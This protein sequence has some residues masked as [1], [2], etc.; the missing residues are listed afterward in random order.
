[1][2]PYLYVNG[3]IHNKIKFLSKALNS[4]FLQYVSQQSSLLIEFF[5]F[6]I[7]FLGNPSQAVAYQSEDL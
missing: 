4:G 2:A 3:L 7:G 1:M 5:S 6:F